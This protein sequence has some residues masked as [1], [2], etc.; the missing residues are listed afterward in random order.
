MATFLVNF[1]T[2][3]RIPMMDPDCPTASGGIALIGWSLGGIHV[4][5]LLAYLDELPEDTQSTLLKYLHTILSHGGTAF[6]LTTLTHT[7]THTH[8]FQMRTQPR[9]AYPTRQDIILTSIYGP[10][11]TIAS[12]SMAF[13]TG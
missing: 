2:E 8:L 3:Q 6:H 4:L 9:S 12:A 13:S 10:R 5:A 11:P 7:R 1:A